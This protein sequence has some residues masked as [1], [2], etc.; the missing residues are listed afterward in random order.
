MTNTSLIDFQNE[1]FETFPLTKQS[2]NVNITDVTSK[3]EIHYSPTF[4]IT[5][6]KYKNT[7][8]PYAVYINSGT[9]EQ[10]FITFNE[11]IEYLSTFFLEV[12]NLFPAPEPEPEP[13]D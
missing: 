3:I 4:S 12:A 10:S 1:F 11:L 7:L 5:V 6:I 2:A 9:K 8:K 13:I